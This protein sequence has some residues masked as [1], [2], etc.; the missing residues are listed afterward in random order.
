MLGNFPMLLCLVLTIPLGSRYYADPYC[1]DMKMSINLLSQFAQNNISK[2]QNQIVNPV[3][4]QSLQHSYCR[5]LSSLRI[6]IT[7]AHL[8]QERLTVVH[9]VSL[10]FLKSSLMGE[11]ML[12][13]YGTVPKACS[14]K[15][16][17]GIVIL[18]GKQTLFNFK[19]VMVTMTKS[20]PGKVHHRKL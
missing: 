14:D 11:L 3:W 13:D 6:E 12:L 7:G 2:L 5:H 20:S 10:Y 15:H 1:L 8:R 17:W 19:H 18:G 16:C 4:V 9:S